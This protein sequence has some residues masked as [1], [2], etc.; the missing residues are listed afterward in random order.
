MRTAPSVTIRY[1]KL[2]WGFWLSF[3]WDAMA[4]LN[5][6]HV[7]SGRKEEN[8]PRGSSYFKRSCW[9][10]GFCTFTSSWVDSCHLWCEPSGGPGCHV[11]G[12]SRGFRAGRMQEYH[13]PQC[14][15]YDLAEPQLCVAVLSPEALSLGVCSLKAL[16][17]A[18]LGF[19]RKSLPLLD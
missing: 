9:D 10:C 3:L 18:N 16:L 12:V 13:I 5:W 15:V 4:C 7:F 19:P 2:A 11:Q 1:I 14:Y 17:P 6:S 8:Q